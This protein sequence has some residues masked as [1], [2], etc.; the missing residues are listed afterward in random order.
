[1]A[2][3]ADP[4]TLSGVSRRGTDLP[5]SR[6]SLRSFSSLGSTSG[7]VAGIVPNAAILAVAQARPVGGIDDGARLG[8]Q[9]G[10]HRRPLLRGI[11]DQHLAHLRAGVAQ[12]REIELHRAAAD[13]PHQVLFAERILV[14]V[15]LGVGRHPLDRDFGPVGIHLL[16]TISGSE[17]IEPW[18]I[19][20]PAERMVI[21]PSGAMRTHGVIGAFA[22]VLACAC[23]IRRTPSLPTAMQNV[24]PPNPASTPR[25][26]RLLSIM[27]MAQAS[28]AARSMAAMMR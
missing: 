25:R 12:L 7:R 2:Y 9:R 13:D 24:S 22:S 8:P 20:A 26:E 4:L 11:G 15:D 16:A 19:S 28:F 5:I 14:A 6:K 3:C 23:D 21:L 1:M 18:P 17:V 27:V 10:R